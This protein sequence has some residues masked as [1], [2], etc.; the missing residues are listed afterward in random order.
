MWQTVY[1]SKFVDSFKLAINLK[2]IY[3]LSKI[4]EES[5]YEKVYAKRKERNIQTLDCQI[6]DLCCVSVEP[7][8]GNH[9]VL[10]TIKSTLK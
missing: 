1:G 10:L 9:P 8:L 5:K 2:G 7:W 3:R 6:A 4:C